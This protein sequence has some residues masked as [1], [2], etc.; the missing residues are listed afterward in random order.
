V[1]GPGPV[2]GRCRERITRSSF[3]AWS[4]IFAAPEHAA[5]LDG[6]PDWVKTIAVANENHRFLVAEQLLEIGLQADILLEPAARNTAPAVA[7]AALH[8]LGEAL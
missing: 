5:P 1:E 2:C 8:A 4:T 3:S 7:A 6:L